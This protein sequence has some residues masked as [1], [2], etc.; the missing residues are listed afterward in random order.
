MRS[1]VPV[2]LGLSALGLLALAVSPPAAM[3]LAATMIAGGAITGSRG[4]RASGFGFAATGV[5]LFLA[6]VLVLAVVEARQDEPVIIG[7]DTGLTPVRP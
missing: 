1:P 7:P 4:D 5:A 2:L 3:A 6:T